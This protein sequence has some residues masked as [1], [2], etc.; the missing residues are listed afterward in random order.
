MRNP[1]NPSFGINPEAFFGR[2]RYL[3][4]Y[5][6]ALD[7][8]NSSDRYFLLLG[9]RGM[10][11]T[12]LLH[13]YAEIARAAQWDVVEAN[14]INVYHALDTYL[15]PKK[16]RERNV[17]IAPKIAIDGIVSAELGQVEV[18]SPSET[19]KPPLSSL[20]CSKLKE[21]KKKR[22]LAI[23]VDEVQKIPEWDASQL[24]DAVQQAKNNGY[25]ISLIC[26]GLPSAYYKFRNL[27]HCTFLKRMQRVNLWLLEIDETLGFLS[28]MFAKIPEILITPGQLE[29]I[30]RFT[31]GHPYLLQLM[32]D[33]IYSQAKTSGANEH[34]R[35]AVSPQ[36]MTSAMRKS[37]SAYRENVLS[38]AL[39]GIRKSTRDYIKL[40]Y[41]SRD[42]L[43]RID[44]EDIEKHYPDAS[45][46]QLESMRR[47]ALNT[48][49]IAWHDPGSRILV[50][51]LPH[52]KYFYEPMPFESRKKQM[53]GDFWPT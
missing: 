47:Y 28:G 42:E 45:P 19:E 23:I 32:G 13:Q 51:A 27:K 16:H 46:K 50:F 29:E 38:E 53:Q 21:M 11:K 30:G 7:N 5:K 36:T 6:E 1:F 52:F 39:K 37:L 3:D 43:G 4:A 35:Y 2:R 31:C 22:G 10:G 12:S 49:V 15:N 25:D 9:T 40:A 8:K 14:A 24:A 18:K 41:M 17:V 34:L 20:L 26:A 44:L 33:N 48:M